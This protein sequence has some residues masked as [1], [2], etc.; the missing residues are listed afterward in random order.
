MTELLGIS[1]SPW[2]HKAKWALQHHLIPF[3]YREYSPGLGAMGLRW[4]LRRRKGI[5]SVPVLFADG[6]A[7]EDSWAIAHWAEQ[8]GS[9]TPLLADIAAMQ[10]WNDRCDA[11]LRY[12]RNRVIM[13]LIESE[14]AL[15]EA[16]RGILPASMAGIARPV[17]RAIAKQTLTKYQPAPDRVALT[18]ALDAV[19]RV[20]GSTHDY[21]LGDFSFADIA[22]AT[23]LEAVE[24][25]GDAYV[26]RGPASREVWRDEELVARHRRLLTW[27]DWVCEQRRKPRK[28]RGHDGAR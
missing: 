24:P 9:G 13:R 27:R 19:E 23:M 11:A 26:R 14:P 17:A 15:D 4:R 6:I 1:Y 22:V 12:A 3:T 10:N 25:V 8:H 16:S 28:K 2:T 5:V 7:V 20:L 18:D 21:L